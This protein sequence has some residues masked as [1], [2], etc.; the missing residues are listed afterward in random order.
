MS[1]AISSSPAENRIINPTMQDYTG[2]QIRLPTGWVRNTN[3][4]H[5]DLNGK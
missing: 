5:Q 4:N 1:A 2:I 3:G